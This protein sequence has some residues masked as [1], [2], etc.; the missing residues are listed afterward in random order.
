MGMISVVH[1]YNL[2]ERK[3]KIKGIGVKDFK[4]DTDSNMNT[5]GFTHLTRTPKFMIV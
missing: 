4:A 3:V 2:K 5:L 1:C